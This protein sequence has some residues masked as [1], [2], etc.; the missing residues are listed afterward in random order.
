M[1]YELGFEIYANQELKLKKAAFQ[2]TQLLI[3]MIY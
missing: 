2:A 1:I 3:R